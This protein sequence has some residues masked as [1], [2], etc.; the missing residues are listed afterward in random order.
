MSYFR[1]PNP[2]QKNKQKKKHIDFGG[3]DLSKVITRF[4]DLGLSFFLQHTVSW[5]PYNVQTY[6]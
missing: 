1:P 4:Q 5:Q 3:M 6:F 2:T